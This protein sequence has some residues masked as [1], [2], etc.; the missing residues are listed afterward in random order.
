MFCNTSLTAAPSLPASQLALS[1]YL[2]MFSGCTNISSVPQN[3]LSVTELAAG[4]YQGMFMG[5]TALTSAPALPATTLALSCYR[6]M[7]HN[8]DSLTT[9]PY[10]PATTLV[11]GCY[12]YMFYSCN[13]LTNINVAF[14]SWNDEEDSTASWMVSIPSNGTFTCPAALDTTTRDD[15][16][17][18]ANWTIVNP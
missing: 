8:C 10:L 18:P 9:A 3:Y 16:H 1:C 6:A 12:W 15:S 14:T 7:F 13:S 11:A 4:C 17:I 5:C 2:A